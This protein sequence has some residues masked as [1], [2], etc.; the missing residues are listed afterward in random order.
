[1]QQNSDFAAAVLKVR[2]HEEILSAREF[3]KL[4]AFL[5]SQSEYDL[6]KF[7]GKGMR[8]LIKSQEQSQRSRSSVFFDK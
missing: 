6:I 4:V 1:M 2:T 8:T 5:A 3:V 7:A